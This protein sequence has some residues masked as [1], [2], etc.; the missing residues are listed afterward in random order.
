MVQKRPANPFISPRLRSLRKEAAMS[1]EEV[2]NRLSAIHG[3]NVDRS[4]VSSWEA[5]KNEP[6][7]SAIIK[8]AH[9]LKIDPGELLK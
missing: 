6:G 1:Q 5:G 8:L 7:A 2:A 4:L 9:A 3:Y